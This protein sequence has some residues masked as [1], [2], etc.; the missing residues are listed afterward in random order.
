M[1]AADLSV[2]IVSYNVRPFLDHCLYSVFRAAGDLQLQVI[3]VD[4]AS[5]D[6]SA[7]MTARR[8]PQVLLIRN[9]ENIGF[10]PANNQAFS[11]ATGEAVLILNPDAF[12]GEDTLITMLARLRES[13]DVGALGPMILLPDG[14]FEP[15]A[16]R[17]FP[18]PWAAFSHLS[19]L[20]ALFP[21]SP[22]FSRYLLTHLNPSHEHDVDALSGCCMMVRRDLLTRLDGFDGSYFMYGEDLDLC[23]RLHGI[24]YRL[25]YTPTARIVHFKG[26]ST[27]RSSVDTDLHSQEAMRLFFRK[28]LSSYV[29]P[30]T[31]AVVNFGFTLGSA[32][33]KFRG[34]KSARQAAHPPPVS[35]S[36]PAFDTAQKLEQAIIGGQLQEARIPMGEMSYVSLI[37][38]VQKLAAQSLNVSLVPIEGVGDD[39]PMFRIWVSPTAKSSGI[40]G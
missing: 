31:R 21:R 28:N 40:T 30:A 16:M 14:R 3:V 35:G 9:R 8:Y 6:G 39:P 23:W 1:A 26:E 19:G 37:T 5:G 34:R 33:H 25:V 7:E 38:L 18:T 20:A 32:A 36:I 17:G 13:P 12:V 22:W 27:R 24:G 15:R 29:S 2:V 11:E 4:N 10:G